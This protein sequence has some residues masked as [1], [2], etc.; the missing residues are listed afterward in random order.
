MIIVDTWTDDH[1]PCVKFEHN[2]TTFEL[3]WT[4]DYV[5]SALEYAEESPKAA[6]K[7]ADLMKLINDPDK[8][9]NEDEDPDKPNQ[10]TTYN[11]YGMLQ[12]TRNR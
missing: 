2:D 4:S 5:V 12:F 9:E 8:I 7:V 3:W 10:V 1:L 6:K 11:E